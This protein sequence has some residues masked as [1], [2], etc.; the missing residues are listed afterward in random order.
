MNT[1]FLSSPAK[2]LVNPPHR[3]VAGTV[4][5]VLLLL[6]LL[7]GLR[8]EAQSPPDAPPP[9]P[10]RFERL[11]LEDGL[12]QNAVLAMRQDRRGWMWVGTQDGLNRYDGYTFTVFRYEPENP[13]SLSHNS[14]L[15]ILEDSAGMLWIGTWGGGLNRYDPRSGQFTRYRHNP[16]DPASLGSDVVA[17]IHEDRR[18]NLWLGTMGGGLDRLNRETGQFE[19]FQHNPADPA[20]SAAMRFR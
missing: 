20:S 11:S 13:N 9:T 8:L 1:R 18:G 19:H 7:P 16:A 12:S 4:A 10:L 6:F 14:I 15:S 3:R 2:I 17:A 5:L